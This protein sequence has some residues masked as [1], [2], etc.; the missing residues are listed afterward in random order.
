MRKLVYLSLKGRKTI[1]KLCNS[2]VS[3]A[4]VAKLLEVSPS[5]VYRELK[6][7]TRLIDG[8][9]LY[10]AKYAHDLSIQSI[11]SRGWHRRLYGEP[12]A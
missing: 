10:D 3:P 1:E 5:T 11:K 9:Y 4:D 6:R 8:K 12:D 2:G 7:G